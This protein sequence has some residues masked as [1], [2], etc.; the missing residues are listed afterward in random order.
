[1]K[2]RPKLLVK[3]FADGA[4]SIKLQL[5]L[6]VRGILH[7]QIEQNRM[8]TPASVALGDHRRG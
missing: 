6:E 3:C 7:E 5:G 2:N 8:I 1:M 4:E